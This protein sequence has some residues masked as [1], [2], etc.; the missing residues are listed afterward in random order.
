MAFGIAF[1]LVA[2]LIRAAREGTSRRR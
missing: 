2:G 1:G